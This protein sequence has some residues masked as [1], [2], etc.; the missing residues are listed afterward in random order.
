LFVNKTM[1]C[2]SSVGT[3][4]EDIPQWNNILRKYRLER[5]L[6]DF[7]LDGHT[8]PEKWPLLNECYLERYG[9]NEGCPDRGRWE[10]L[11]ASTCENFDPNSQLIGLLGKRH[12]SLGSSE[13]TN[14]ARAM[15][16]FQNTQLRLKLREYIRTPPPIKYD[17]FLSHVQSTSQALCHNVAEE[18]KEPT[19]SM[20]NQKAAPEKLSLWFDKNKTDWEGILTIIASSRIFIIISTSAYFARPYCCFELMCAIALGKKI[21]LLVTPPNSQ[22]H[23]SLEEFRTAAPQEFQNE[24]RESEDANLEAGSSKA[25]SLW[26][27]SVRH[28]ARK[29]RDT[30][31]LGDMRIEE[32][33]KLRLEAE[34]QTA[35]LKQLEQGKSRR[36]SSLF[37]RQSVRTNGTRRVVTRAFLVGPGGSGKTTIFKTLQ[38]NSRV[39][40]ETELKTYKQVIHSNIITGVRDN[41]ELNEIISREEKKWEGEF[42]EGPRD[43]AREIMQEIQVISNSTTR[44][45]VTP[46]LAELINALWAKDSNKSLEKTLFIG[47]HRQCTLTADTLGYFFGEVLRIGQKMY[48]PSLEDCLYAKARTNGIVEQEIVQ[49]QSRTLTLYDAGGQ[50]HERMKWLHVMRWVDLC[51]FT[52]SLTGYSQSLFE[53]RETNRMKEALSLFQ[54]LISSNLL[55]NTSIALV[56]TKKDLLKTRLKMDRFTNYFPNFKGDPFSTE[57]VINFTRSMFLEAIQKQR[58]RGNDTLGDIPVFVINAMDRN[59]VKQILEQPAEK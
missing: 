46:E 5:L 43:V 14:I 47:H 58:G 34:A 3:V 27:T 54:N 20:E 17:G 37:S 7:K 57:Q 30:Q 39:L 36:Q 24:M 11:L 4:R 18:L 19:A 41:I 6:A 21:L 9:V 48:K 8:D 56:F 40:T 33:A 16:F 12:A 49:N 51:L 13:N 53:D 25:G 31:R 26:V 45:L 28:L 29:I 35:Q 38:H 2:F 52:V 32:L 55:Q 50:R 23:L 44:A 15:K 59:E 22:Q 1:G 42:G 10:Q